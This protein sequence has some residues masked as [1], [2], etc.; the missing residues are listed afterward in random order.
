MYLSIPKIPPTPGLLL[1]DQRRWSR[2]LSLPSLLPLQVITTVTVLYTHMSSTSSS[3]SSISVTSSAPLTEDNAR[4]TRISDEDKLDQLSCAPGSAERALAGAHRRTSLHQFRLRQSLKHPD[5]SPNPHFWPSV[6]PGGSEM[7]WL[8]GPALRKICELFVRI[9]SIF[10]STDVAST[11]SFTSSWA[12]LMLT[13]S[14]VLCK[15]SK[16]DARPPG[17]SKGIPS[18]SPST[19]CDYSHDTDFR[20]KSTSPQLFC[21]VPRPV[22]SSLPQPNLGMSPRSNKRTR[23][24]VD[25][26]PEPSL[27]AISSSSYSFSS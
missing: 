18:S 5:F 12:R 27:S 20:V 13:K 4:S 26:A 8:S 22:S 24:S 16:H 14:D 3:S 21:A 11:T 19:S 9:Q 7:F 15:R 1:V 2:L 25:T 6:Q 10:P 23:M 17:E